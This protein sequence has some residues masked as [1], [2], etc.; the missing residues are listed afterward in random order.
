MPIEQ[1]TAQKRGTTFSCSFSERDAIVLDISVS[2]R[3][4]NFHPPDEQKIN[5]HIFACHVHSFTCIRFD[6][7]KLGLPAKRCVAF[8]HDELDDVLVTHS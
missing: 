4:S 8:I 5:A 6:I 1:K 7:W 2:P 3:Y